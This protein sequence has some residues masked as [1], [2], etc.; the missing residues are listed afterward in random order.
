MKKRISL[1]LIVIAAGLLV[2]V[3]F[4]SCRRRCKVAL[5]HLKTEN[6]LLQGY[7]LKDWNKGYIKLGPLLSNSD[8]VR[9]D[10]LTLKIDFGQNYV[11]KLTSKQKK[12][13]GFFINSAFALDGCPD[14]GYQGHIDKLATLKITSDSAYDASHL[15]GATLNDLFDVYE[16]RDGYTTSTWDT[17][18]LINY[19]SKFPNK[20]P[21]EL[22]LRLKSNATLSKKHTFNVHVT[23]EEGQG[24]SAQTNSIKLY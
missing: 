12:Y 13:N 11:A 10:S 3:I 20:T 5:E 7:K 2:D 9:F 4:I 24:F 14:N 22:Y 6:V 21:L 1:T 16:I 17:L 23:L 15:A 18:P 8:S 19:T